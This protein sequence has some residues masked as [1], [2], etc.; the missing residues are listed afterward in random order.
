MSDGHPRTSKKWVA[1]AVK[2][3]LVDKLTYR[4]SE[5]V[6]DIRREYSISIPYH[7][8]FNDQCAGKYAA[9]FKKLLR[10]ILQ[11]IAY[12]VTEQ[13]YQDAMMTM[14]LNSTDAKEWVLRNDVDHWSYAR[15]PG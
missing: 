14:K 10:K 9:P 11:R 4:A 5:M 12:A 8:N 6:R 15:F 1:N 3:K 7:Q 2:G 13:E